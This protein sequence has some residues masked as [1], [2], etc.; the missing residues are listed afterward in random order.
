ME[1]RFKKGDVVYERT[2]PTQKIIIT[3]VVAGLYYGKAQ[4]RIGQKELVFFERDLK[5][6]MIHQNELTHSYK[7]KSIN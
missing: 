4:E 3:R 2:R 7:S 5:S 1:N 6:D